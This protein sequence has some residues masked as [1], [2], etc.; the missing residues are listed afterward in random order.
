M[1]VN[2]AQASR[3]VR[4]IDHLYPGFTNATVFSPTDVMPLT[5]LP[6]IAMTVQLLISLAILGLVVARAVNVFS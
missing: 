6:K 1:N 5:P 3:S 4:F 2:L